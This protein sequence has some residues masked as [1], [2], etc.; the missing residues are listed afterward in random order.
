MVL[1]RTRWAHEYWILLGNNEGNDEG[2]VA[3][4]ERETREN[5]EIWDCPK[6]GD[7]GRI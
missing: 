1:I 3:V 6:K 5:R 7:N 2:T 4:E